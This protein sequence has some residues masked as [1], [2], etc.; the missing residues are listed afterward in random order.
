MVYASADAAPARASIVVGDG[1]IRFVGEPA[2]AR[3]LAAGARVRVVDLRGRFVFPGFADAHLHLSGIGHEREVAD[4]RGAADA[5]DAAARIA[6]MASKRPPGAWVEATR[7]GPEPL[8][9]PPVSGRR[10]PRRGAREPARRGLAGRRARRLGELGRAEGRRHRRRDPRSRGRP[11]LAPRRRIADGRP[12]GQR[13]G[14]RVARAARSDGGG[15]REAA[16]GGCG[17]VRRLRADRGAGRLG[18]RPRRDRGAR[19]ARRPGRPADPDLRDGVSE[20][21]RARGGALE[22]RPHRRGLRSG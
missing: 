2:K 11:D 17:R 3:T 12:R 5:G 9:W 10:H 6:K 14:A 15:P 16:A 13:E 18:L 22:G 4:L 19:A 21:R 1:R 20:A 7:L 8:A